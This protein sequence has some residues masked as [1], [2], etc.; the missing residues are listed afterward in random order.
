MWKHE[1][2]MQ[3]CI[4]NFLQGMDDW[5]WSRASIDQIGEEGGWGHATITFKKARLEK[6]SIWIERNDREE[7]CLTLLPR[8]V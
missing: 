2:V 3:R 4:T 6:P 8:Y 5:T 7:E 1:K